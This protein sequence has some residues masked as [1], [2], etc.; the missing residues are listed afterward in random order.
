[1]CPNPVVQV[2]LV[3]NSAKSYVVSNTLYGSTVYAVDWDAVFNGLNKKYRKAYVRVHLSGTNNIAKSTIS[4]ATG[5][6]S[7]VGFGSPFGYSFDIAGLIVS[8]LQYAT[9]TQ[10]SS[11][12]LE[13]GYY[14]NSDTRGNIVAP[15][16][17]TPQGVMPN[18]TVQMTQETGAVMANSNLS[19]YAIT[20]MFELF[21][22][23]EP[24][25]PSMNMKGSILPMAPMTG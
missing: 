17:Y 2:T 8:D 13:T 21:D 11:D 25:Q 1:M 4:G 22:E 18:F 14:L 19:S 20:I 23:I 24:Q 12:V 3:S 15:V 5:Y 10:I 9:A 7:L 6:I 16:I